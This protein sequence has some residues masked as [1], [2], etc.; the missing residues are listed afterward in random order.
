MAS[1]SSGHLDFNRPK[2]PR[3]NASTNSAAPNLM[4]RFTWILTVCVTALAA[5]DEALGQQ[6]NRLARGAELWN[7]TCNQCH[8]RRSPV[9]RTDSQ[10]DVIVSHMRTRA[11][12]T[13]AE[14]Q[15]LVAFLQEANGD[16]RA[17]RESSARSQVA[18]SNTTAP[19]RMR[20]DRHGPPDGTREAL[21]LRS[22]SFWPGSWF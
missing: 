4:I 12:L 9:E 19:A 14:V 7:L 6:S 16:E 22:S 18:D 3:I 8:N 13:K 10:W 1:R 17:E 15:A 5:P 11:N 21:W 2:T 20:V